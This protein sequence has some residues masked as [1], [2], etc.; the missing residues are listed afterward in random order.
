MVLDGELIAWH[1]E[2]GNIRA[3]LKLAPAHP[4]NTKSTKSSSEADQGTY[5]GRGVT[6]FS[7]RCLRDH[8]RPFTQ[9]LHLVVR[10]LVLLA[11]HLESR[12]RTR[13]C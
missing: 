12:R 11:L 5:E 1:K 10:L 13:E 7:T 2:S 3:R 6:I 9:E 8:V 4:T